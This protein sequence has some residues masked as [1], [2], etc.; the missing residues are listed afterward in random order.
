MSIILELW[1]VYEHYGRTSISDMYRYV[2]TYVQLLKKLIL[3]KI[4]CSL[5]INSSVESVL[6]FT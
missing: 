3:A 4:V 6:H 5:N 1:D 2:R